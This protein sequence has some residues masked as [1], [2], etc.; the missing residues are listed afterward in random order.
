MARFSVIITSFGVGQRVERTVD[1]VRR[2]TLDDVELMA[3]NRISSASIF[4]RDASSPNHY[5]ESMNG[6]EDW[7]HWISILAAGWSCRVI[8][9][10]L[11][12]YEWRS[13]SLGKA[14]NQRAFALVEA[15]VERHPELYRERIASVLA[16]KHRQVLPLE[17][18]AHRAW[19][20]GVDAE[21]EFQRVWGLVGELGDKL[22]T[23]SRSVDE[24][25]GELRRVEEVLRGSGPE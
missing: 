9:E 12:H 22:E 4:R 10:F 1:S 5:A 2:Q 23:Q 24:L 7:D 16:H 14:S 11:I 8:P 19:Q 18:E 15:I 3:T 13:G 21:R 6:Y 25:T 17:S 20:L